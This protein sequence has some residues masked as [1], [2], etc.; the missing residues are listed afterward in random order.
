MENAFVIV[1]HGFSP[2]GWLVPGHDLEVG[3]YRK[4]FED[5][6]EADA[7]ARALRDTFVDVRVDR[8]DVTRSVW[9]E[10]PI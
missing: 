2:T 5:E 3:E 8:A 7:W 6:G 10:T 1:D 9:Q 4:R